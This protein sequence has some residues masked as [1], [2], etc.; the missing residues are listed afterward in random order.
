MSYCIVTLYSTTSRR[1]YEQDMIARSSAALLWGFYPTLLITCRFFYQATITIVIFTDDSYC[2]VLFS[3]RGND[4]YY[5]LTPESKMKWGVSGDQLDANKVLGTQRISEMARD[6]NIVNMPL[7]SA[8]PDVVRAK[9][10]ARHGSLVRGFAQLDPEGRGVI[11]AEEFERNLPS[12]L[13]VD[14]VPDKVG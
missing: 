11:S 13:G 2:D 8:T 1:V 4:L 12:V 3:R 10:F 9:I 7:E 6:S 5:I 14:S